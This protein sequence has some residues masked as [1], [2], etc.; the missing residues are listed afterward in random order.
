MKRRR[1]SVDPLAR[2]QHWLAA[3]GVVRSDCIALEPAL[4]AC[5]GAAWGVR[6]VRDIRTEELLCSIP[7]AAILS[8]RNTSI[9]ELLVKEQLGGG[10]GLTVAV[11]H[12]RALGKSSLWYGYFESLPAREFLPLFWS[13]AEAAQLHGTE[14][15]GRAEAD[16]EAV[17]EDWQEHV[18]PL[19]AKYRVLVPGCG[20]WSSEA[21][22]V[23]ASWVSSRAFFVDRYHGMS[24]VPLADVFN[25]KPSVVAVSDEYAVA[26]EDEEEGEGEDGSDDHA[27]DDEE[28][29]GVEEQEEDGD[30]KDASTAG[31]EE[32]GQVSTSSARSRLGDGGPLMKAG[33]D[34]RLHIAIYDH[35]P[36]VTPPSCACT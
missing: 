25:H 15:E 11:M 8:I 1:A 23:A 9:A 34:L 21:F 28:E 3:K 7:K 36:H 18:A 10:L 16:R 22:C 24:L 32:E 13:Q 5:S 30:D 4:D 35:V 2:F 19:V 26:E 31:G 6:A 33:Q 27:D 12:E 17:E 14:I 20:R 29:D